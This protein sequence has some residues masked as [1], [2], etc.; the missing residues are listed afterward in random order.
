MMCHM[1]FYDKEYQIQQ[2][3]KELYLQLDLIK[4]KK[5]EEFYYD[6]S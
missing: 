6:F 2:K 3:F 4:I 5:I 1:T